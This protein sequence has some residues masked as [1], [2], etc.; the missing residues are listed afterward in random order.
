MTLRNSSM[1]YRYFVLSGGKTASIA[2]SHSIMNTGHEVCAAHNFQFWEEELR[3]QHQGVTL[4]DL[5]RENALHHKVHIIT[6]YREPVSRSISSFFQMF[7]YMNDRERRF[8]NPSLCMVEDGK[9]VEDYSVEQLFFIFLNYR[10]TYAWNGHHKHPFMDVEK[11]GINVLDHPFDKKL[12][13]M[14]VEKDNR[15]YLIIAFYAMQNLETILRRELGLHHL[16]MPAMN[17]S[18]EKYPHK[19]IEFKRYIEKSPT[20]M[21]QIRRFYEYPEK[22]YINHFYPSMKDETE[23]KLK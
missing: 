7:P 15:V 12:G 18:M 16:Q 4:A 5:I 8:G 13:Y 22:A 23:M 17:I 9:H 21:F 2:I 1:D 14:Q 6:C 10:K 19:Y 3:A 11:Y 20:R